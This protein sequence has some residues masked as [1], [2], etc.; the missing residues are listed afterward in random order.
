M[1]AT[2]ISARQLRGLLAQ[3]SAE[4]Y[5]MCLVI[6]HPSFAA[7][8][9]LVCDQQPLV[10]AAGTYEPFAFSMNLPN[11]DDSAVPQVQIT[12]DNVDP[13]ILQAIR[14]LPPGERPGVLIDVVTAAEPDTQCAGPIS[15]K[16][17]T[18]DYDESTITGTIGPDNDFL[19]L[20]V[21]YATYTPTN[22]PG[23]FA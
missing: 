10:R 8:Y 5:L 19:N 7:P 9:M 22:S 17:L 18:A 23:L 1:S 15:F 11:E 16:I 4:V 6:S 14:T 2:T 21:P 13:K 20:V 12:I 3:E